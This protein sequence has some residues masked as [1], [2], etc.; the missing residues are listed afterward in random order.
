VQ[1][2]QGRPVTERGVEVGHTVV[3]QQI[4]RFQYPVTPHCPDGATDGRGGHVLEH[5]G[6]L[7]GDGAWSL[8]G[9]ADP[10]EAD[11]IGR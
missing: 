3:P 5:H 9:I 10:V 7:V 6:D 1:V 4:R 11:G 2:L 8:R